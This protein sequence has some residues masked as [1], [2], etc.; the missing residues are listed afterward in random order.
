MTAQVHATNDN[1]DQASGSAIE[2]I[3][4]RC[5]ANGTIRNLEEIN[6]LEDYG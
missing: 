4:S 3:C 5:A 1:F 6:Y 2:V